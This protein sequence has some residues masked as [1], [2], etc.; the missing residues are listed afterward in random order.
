MIIL[1]MT[2]AHI[3]DIHEVEKASFSVPWSKGAFQD[4]LSN[5]LANYYVGEIDEQIIGY[6]GIWLIADEGHITNIAIDPCKQGKGY[7]QKLLQETMKQLADKGCK[8]MTLEVRTSNQAAIGLYEKN[9]FKI[10]GRRKN[11]YTEPK[12]DALIMWKYENE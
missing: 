10:V 5:P 12:E 9:G 7:G 1:P 8:S 3:D 11:Y 2:D 6:M 4:E